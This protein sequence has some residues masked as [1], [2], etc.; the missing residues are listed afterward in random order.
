M[1][2]IELFSPK[3]RLLLTG[4]IL[5]DAGRNH[6]AV[7]GVDP[8]V[9]YESRD[10]ADDGQKALIDQPPRLSRVGH[11]L[12]PPYRCVH[13]LTLAPF[14]TRL[15]ETRRVDSFH[16]KH[17]ATMRSAVHT[18]NGLF[19][20]PFLPSHC[21]KTP[22][23]TFSEGG[24]S[25]TQGFR[26]YEFWEVKQLSRASGGSPRSLPRRRLAA[27]CFARCPT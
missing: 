5:K 6:Y 15:R 12:V 20:L 1:L 27:Q 19:F 13:R 18:P 24:I 7:P 4:R 14:L 3:G 16:H 17:G 10:C 8:V 2:R 26:G 9:S 22:F 11:A 21:L 25:E 23:R